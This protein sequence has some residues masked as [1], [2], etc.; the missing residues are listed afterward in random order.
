MKTAVFMF[1]RAVV[2]ALMPTWRA[3]NSASTDL[4]LRARSS[5][6]SDRS[7][8]GECTVANSRSMCRQTHGNS[9]KS[10]SPPARRRQRQTASLSRAHRLV[11]IALPLFWGRATPH[12]HRDIYPE[13]LPWRRDDQGMRDKMNGGCIANHHLARLGKIVVDRRH[14]NR[15][16]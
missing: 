13:G 9:R 2:I 16:K 4:S 12:V 6:V 3:V 5:V 1:S 11:A 10:T 7:I 14:R 8:I 15:G